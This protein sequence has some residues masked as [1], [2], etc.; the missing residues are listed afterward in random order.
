MNNLAR[1]IIKG[2]VLSPGELKVICHTVEELDMD[3]ISFGS[4]QDI[5][6]PDQVDNL[7]LKKIG[8][9]DLVTSQTDRVENIMSSYV[10]SDIFPSTL[11]LTG[12]KYLYLLE[13]FRKP[14]ALKVNITDPKQRLVP[15]F[16]GHLNFI[17]SDHEDYWFLYVRLPDW[18]KTVVYPALVFSW[19]MAKITSTIESILKE[20]PD[21]V[22]MIFELVNDAIDT[23]NITIDKPLFLPFHPFP[24]YEGMNRI[25]N[26]RYWL[27]LYWR[28]NRYDLN[29]LKAMCALCVECKIGKI[30]ITPWKSFI[31]KGIP[32]NAK[33]QWEKFLGKFGINVRH[34]MLELNWHIPVGNDA[35][36]QLKKYLVKNFDENDISTYGLTFG[37]TDYVKKA[38]YFT[39]IV[40]EKNN[41]PDDYAGFK[42][43]DTYN[44]LHAKNFD[45]NMREYI[46]YVQDIDKNE[47]SDLLIELSKLYFEQLGAENEETTV[48]KTIE[49]TTEVE[50]YQCKNCLTVYNEVYG[51]LTQNIA[52]NTPFEEL[53]DN[54]RCSICDAPKSDFEKKIFIQ[55][56]SA[57]INHQ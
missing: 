51:D 41:P 12:D 50:V 54:Y 38:Y 33:V 20:E 31:V 26:D 8:N 6:L 45:P 22:D 19:D 30:Q 32:A 1:L 29:F 9:F 2:G 13:Q 23:N 52:E 39:S 44:I 36:Y 56:V 43:R 21:S 14:T 35:A 15:L 25:G 7:N 47:L 37:I 55:K 16:T 27:G 4:R 5:L 17:A 40:I 42:T 10:C 53:N 57:T 46:I 18:S 34:S 48:K 28:N 24:Y 49:E 11:W 3:A